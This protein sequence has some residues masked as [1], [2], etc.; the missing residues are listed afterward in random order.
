MVVSSAETIEVLSGRLY[1]SCVRILPTDT[2]EAHYFSTDDTLLYE[3]Y[4]GDFGPLNISAVTKYCRLLASKMADTR[5]ERKRIVHCCRAQH[6]TRANSVLL[7][8][9]WNMIH[10]NMSP[11]QAFAPFTQ[12]KPALCPY[13]DA[14]LGA[15]CYD[16]TVLHCL[17]GLAKARQMGWY[18]VE[19]FDTDA[20]DYYERV[21][22]G[23]F[24]WIVPG[25]F[26]SFSGPTQTPIAYVDGITTNTPETYF[27][28]F[29][30]NTVTGVVRFNNKVYDRRKFLDAGFHHYDL[31]FADGGNPTDPIVRRFLEIAEKEEGA[32]AIHCK[33][34][35][36]RTGTLIALYLM[37][38]FELTTAEVIAW[39]RFCRPGSV[40]GP[41]QLFLQSMEKQMWREGE[42]SLGGVRTYT[43]PR[44]SNSSSQLHASLEGL[45]LSSPGSPGSATGRTGALADSG[46]PAPSP[47][48][49][50]A[51]VRSRS[52]GLK[53][54]I[55]LGRPSPSRVSGGRAGSGW[56][57]KR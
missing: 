11:E 46:S 7:L 9:C 22:N 41:Q 12:L 49:S 14:S 6:D 20:Y 45:S 43:P 25:K 42:E 38:H 51:T 33:A 2:A 23:D 55:S 24:N 37:K 54:G 26:L 52:L 57:I 15:P 50:P 3:P 18:D 21:D 4:Y 17:R 28:Y 30:K 5:L 48:T 31:Y 44:G 35:L 53:G 47:G 32:L 36:G 34:G 29:A 16:L 56:S 19:T 27:D 40:I 8:C 13:R 10:N 1:W 39:L